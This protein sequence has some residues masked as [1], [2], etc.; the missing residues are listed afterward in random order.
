M[1]LTNDQ[2]FYEKHSQKIVYSKGYLNDIKIKYG[3]PHWPNVIVI[4]YNKH[5][6][7]LN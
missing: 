4:S 2:S 5:F 7:Y 6:D 3:W 1:P